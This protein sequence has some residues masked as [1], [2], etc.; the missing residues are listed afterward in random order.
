M[1]TINKLTFVPLTIA[2]ETQPEPTTA[3]QSAAGI[4]NVKDSFESAVPSNNEIFTTMQQSSQSNSQMLRTAESGVDPS[5][6][7]ENI[8][9]V[10]D[11]QPPVP[12]EPPEKTGRVSSALSINDSDAVGDAIDDAAQLV[13]DVS[14]EV[15]DAGNVAYSDIGDALSEYGD[16]FGNLVEKMTEPVGDLVNGDTVDDVLDFVSTA[17]VDPALIA[18]RYNGLEK[19]ADWIQ[20]TGGDAV[21]FVRDTTK[22]VRDMTEDVIDS[23][24]DAASDAGDFAE[25]VLDTVTAPAYDVVTSDEMDDV[26]NAGKDV[27]DAI[28]D[29]PGAI[30]DLG[31]S[32]A[33]KAGDAAE[34]AL[35]AVGDAAEDVKD[36][37]DDLDWP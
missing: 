29:V 2:P 4:A 14:N 34:D 20:N 15:I 9:D 13:E 30:G 36:W 6:I 37:L 35:D 10:R 11:P 28:G 1:S 25:K 32:L 12:P 8:M 21:R 16:S 26:I 18:M 3:E 19:E 5:S 22:K 27:I 23:V 24:G 31:E 17:V 7:F 33:D